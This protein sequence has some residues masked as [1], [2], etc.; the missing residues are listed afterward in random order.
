MYAALAPKP[1]ERASLAAASSRARRFAASAGYGG[2]GARARG[3][4]GERVRF[5]ELARSRQRRRRLGKRAVSEGA[6]RLARGLGFRLRLDHVPV[7]GR[8]FRF[9]PHEP[10]Q[11]VAPGAVAREHRLAHLRKQRTML[12]EPEP[13]RL[14][15]APGN[16]D[17]GGLAAE[18]ARKRGG[19]G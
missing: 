15:D 1:G 10:A 7:R 3:A 6:Q 19:I 8:D 5:F 11:H 13:Q 17:V 16:A 18:L 14:G 9:E 12:D 2:F 4:G